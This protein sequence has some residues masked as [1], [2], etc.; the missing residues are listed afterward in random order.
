MPRELSSTGKFFDPDFQVIEES[1]QWMAVAK[2]PHLQ[3]H[4]SKPGD[5]P[6]LWDGLQELLVYDLANGGQISLINRLDRETSG[7]VLVAKTRQA[8]RELALAMER[9]E[10]QKHYLALVHGWP[11]WEEHCHR[12]PL[13]PQHEVG[14][15]QIYVKQVVA[16][17]GRACQTTFRVLE[18]WNSPIGPLAAIQALPETGRMHQIRVHL[19]DLGHP[20]L[21]DKIYGPDETCYL[22][23]IEKGWTSDLAK[24]LHHP[25]HALHAWRLHWRKHRWEALW[26]KDLERWWQPERLPDCSLDGQ[27]AA[28]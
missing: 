25:R 5:P 6:T 7:V 23:F 4:P 19:S 1:S 17:G 26:P 21:G 28:P 9:R 14:P 16:P 20:L 18:R 27:S 12:G 3:V 15:F 22:D 13:R 24:R 8:A 10:F 2:P 11:T